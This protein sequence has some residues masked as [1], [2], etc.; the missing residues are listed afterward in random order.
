MDTTLKTV[1]KMEVPLAVKTTTEMV[2]LPLDALEKVQLAEA[3]GS[4]IGQRDLLKEE[5]KKTV[6]AQ[7]GAIQALEG[8]IREHGKTL[9]NGYHQEL[10]TVEHHLDFNTETVK[11]VFKGKVLKD[12]PMT[13]EEKQLDLDLCLQMGMELKAPKVSAKPEMQLAGKHGNPVA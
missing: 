13:A 10:A 1:K 6:T 2:N 4:L 11:V 8:T 3:M 5:L 9:V 7:R 12:R